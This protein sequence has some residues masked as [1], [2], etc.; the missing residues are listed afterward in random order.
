MSTVCSALSWDANDNV[1]KMPGCPSHHSHLCHV[2]EGIHQYLVLQIIL[3][4]HCG[5]TTGFFPYVRQNLLQEQVSRP[6]SQGREQNPGVEHR[7]ELPELYFCDR[8]GFVI[9]N[10]DGILHRVF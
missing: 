9:D 7:T 2:S 6:E 10:S 3:K 1:P 5:C 4:R 8:A